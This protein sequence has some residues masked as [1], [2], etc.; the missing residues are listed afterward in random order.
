MLEVDSGT[1]AAEVLQ[2]DKPV[3][4]D[5]WGPRCG[6]CLALMPQVEKLEAGFADKVKFVKIDAS[7]NRRLC[8]DLKVT[9][10]PTYLFYRDGES[11]ARLSGGDIKIGD[12][13]V[14]VTNLLGHDGQLAAKD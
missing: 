13:E 10:L 7:K 6:P 4:V 11:M 8:L 14:H 3:L 2:A 9:S 1:F 12:I 5:F